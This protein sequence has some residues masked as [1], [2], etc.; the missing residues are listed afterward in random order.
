MIK[1]APAVWSIEMD[2]KRQKLIKDGEIEMVGGR[3]GWVTNRP[4]Q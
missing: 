1:I 2:P 4:L 3:G